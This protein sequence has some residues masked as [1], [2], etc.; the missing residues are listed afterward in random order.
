M[1]RRIRGMSEELVATVT[2]FNLD[3]VTRTVGDLRFTTERVMFSRTGGKTDIIEVFFGFI[4]LAVAA[5]KSRKTSEALRNRPLEELA[6]EAQEIYSYVDLEKVIVK[7]R[8]LISSSIILKPRVGKRKKFWG[9]RKELQ[10][11]LL[12]INRLSATG[13]QIFVD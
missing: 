3:G 10:E 2:Q 9:K 7:P 1:R 8:T 13:L 6:A 11:F 4:A 12:T 5:N